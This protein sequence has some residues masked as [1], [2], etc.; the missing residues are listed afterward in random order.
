ME[1]ETIQGNRVI[2]KFCGYKY[3]PNAVLNGEKGVL[4][5]KDKLSLHANITGKDFCPK[6]H[7]SWDWI[8]PVIKKMSDLKI[9]D[10]ILVNNSAMTYV[11]K[12]GVVKRHLIKLDLQNTWLAVIEFINWYNKNKQS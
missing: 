4:K 3:L 8:I 7:S 11:N 2:A 9:K 1:T 10:G 6:Y 5:K 12:L